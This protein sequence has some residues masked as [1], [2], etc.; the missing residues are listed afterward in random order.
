MQLPRGRVQR[1]LGAGVGHI[2]SW[3]GACQAAFNF[4]HAVLDSFVNVASVRMAALQASC[5]WRVRQRP[6][7]RQW[8][9]QRD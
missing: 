6:Q 9:M 8:S 7:Q 3:A 1:V 2:P 4:C 5:G